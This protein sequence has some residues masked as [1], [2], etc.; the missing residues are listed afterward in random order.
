AESDRTTVELLD[1]RLE[2]PRIHVVEAERVHVEQSERLVG[3]VPRDHAVALHL[4]EVTQ[5]AE[6]SIC[7]PWSAAGAPRDFRGPGILDVDV[8]HLGR[9]FDDQ[10]EVFG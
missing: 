6:Q 3:D 10:L 9:A 2:D 1:D 7:Y 5:A 4:G 8:H